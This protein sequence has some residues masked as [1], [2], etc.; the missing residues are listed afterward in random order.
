MTTPRIAAQL[1][2]PL[3]GAVIVFVVARHTIRAMARAQLAER[4]G[5]FAQLLDAAIDDV[6]GDRDHVRI[7]P[8]DAAHDTLD[9]AALDGGP[10]VDVA[11]LHDR[12]AAQ[13][14]R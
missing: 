1:G 2:D 8:V 4:R 14:G 6:A 11:Q 3:V 5:V 9:V 13:S 10:H 12:E 7:E